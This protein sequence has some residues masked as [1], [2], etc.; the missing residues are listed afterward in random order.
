MSYPSAQRH[1]H[2]KSLERMRAELEKL[3]AGDL[4]RT[5]LAAAARFPDARAVAER[6]FA[7]V[8][9]VTQAQEAPDA[10]PTLE[11][12]RLVSSHGAV[13]G[14]LTSI[15]EWDGHV[16]TYAGIS[17]QQAL[18]N[19]RDELMTKLDEVD[20]E[21]HERTLTVLPPR[22][23]ASWE[24]ATLRAQR[25]VE[26]AEEAL[27]RIANVEA[28]AREATGKAGVGANADFFRARADAHTRQAAVWMK[29]VVG[30]VVVAAA[31]AVC[32]IR[33]S[34][35]ITT[36]AQQA[37]GPFA[38]LLVS[39]S[40]VLSVVVWTMRMYRSSLHNAVVSQHR[41]DALRTFRAFVE[42]VQDD[43]QIRNA[44][45][46][47]ATQCVFHPQ[48]TGYAGS[49][50]PAPPQVQLLELIKSGEK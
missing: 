24:G 14:A 33:Y 45:L 6:I 17:H 20:A 10:I 28:A 34:W 26:E 50:S 30:A 41:D 48:D 1:D 47:Q 15:L 13:V 12:Q 38:V 49:A 11:M 21:L 2:L 3:R 29:A 5:D 46:M 16:S 22:G 7:N 8:D 39:L 35:Q 19:R 9:R 44:V 36:G 42:G 37:F 31:F 40:G 18:V 43:V 23:N 32:A 25:A 4:E 27:R